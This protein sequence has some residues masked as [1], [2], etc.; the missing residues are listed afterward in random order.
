MSRGGSAA[1]DEAG[2]DDDDEF[3]EG[4][5]EGEAGES[6]VGEDDE[7]LEIPRDGTPGPVAVP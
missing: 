2:D 6:E 5:D 3:D 1:G 7:V 4:E